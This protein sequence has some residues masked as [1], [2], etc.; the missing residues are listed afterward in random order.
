MLYSISNRLC[1]I[2]APKSAKETAVS[3]GISSGIGALAGVIEVAL[4][5]PHV[6]WK[7]AVQVSLFI[8]IGSSYFGYRLLAKS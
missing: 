1:D 4:Q 5:Q 8:L 3:P 7:N 2:M 6:A